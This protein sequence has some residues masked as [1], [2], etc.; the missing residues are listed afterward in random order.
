MS[1]KQRR[2]QKGLEAHSHSCVATLNELLGTSFTYAFDWSCIPEG[3]V[4]W[5]WEQ[6]DLDQL[7]YNSYYK[8]IE[9]CLM[10]LFADDFYKEAIL[11]QI[12]GF[13]VVPGKSIASF[14]FAEGTMRIK[15][16][17]GV[18]QKGGERSMFF[19]DVV[20]ALKNTIDNSLSGDEPSQ[21]APQPDPVAPIECA[22]QAAPQPA[23]EE[24]RNEATQAPA[25]ETRATTLSGRLKLRRGSTVIATFESSGRFGQRGDGPN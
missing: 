22:P 24:S 21:A 17:L 16:T 8:P 6:E 1:L 14:E 25:G 3:V 2:I 12:K 15:H 5:N 23:S 9:V 7:L 11:E 20:K 19:K 10:D 4:G 13:S 18:N